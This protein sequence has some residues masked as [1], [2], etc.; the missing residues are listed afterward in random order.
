MKKAK[1]GLSLW[2]PFASHYGGGSSS[3]ISPLKIWDLLPPYLRIDTVRAK[4]RKLII[5]TIFAWTTPLIVEYS[6][7]K[8][9]PFLDCNVTTNQDINLSSSIFRK[10]KTFTG[11]GTNYNSFINSSFI[12]NSVTHLISLLTMVTNNTFLKTL[13]KF[14]CIVLISKIK[15][16]T[17]KKK[18]IYLSLQI[19][20]TPKK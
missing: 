5:L 20:Q 16:A 14:I 4:N 15:P 12:N 11:P 19:F 8:I 18:L 7:H 13:H 6:N 9:L 2:T 1:F 10:K 17:G 3:A